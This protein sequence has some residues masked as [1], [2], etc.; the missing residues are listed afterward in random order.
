LS[1]IILSAS[2]FLF[3]CATPW[4]STAVRLNEIQV[5]GTHNSYHQRAPEPLGILLSKRAPEQAPGLAYGHRPLPEQLSLGIRQIELDCF[6]DPE[7]G[8]YAEPRG[9]KW[10]AQGGLAPVPDHDP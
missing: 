4:V 2:C 8:R 5:I 1:P 7:G 3:G 6:A 9:V 10:A